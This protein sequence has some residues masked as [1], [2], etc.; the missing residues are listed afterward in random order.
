MFSVPQKHRRCAATARHKRPP[1]RRRPWHAQKPLHGEREISIASRPA[2]PGRFREGRRPLADD[3]RA[4]KSDLPE[5]ARK[6]ANK[7]ASP[8]RSPWER[9][10]GA[11]ENAELQKHGPDAGRKPCHARRPAY[12]KPSQEQTDKLTALLHH[13]NI[14]LCRASF[15][16]TKEDCCPRRR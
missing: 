8:R 9:G 2:W 10:A 15:L 1:R 3:E 12:E 11:K 7:A 14:E 4:E 5:V 13:V 6:R 16:R